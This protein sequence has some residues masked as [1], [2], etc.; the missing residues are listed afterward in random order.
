M[1]IKINNK[2]SLYFIEK[3]SYEIIQIQNIVLK[4]GSYW[5]I[6]PVICKLLNIQIYSENE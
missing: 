3:F 6:F 2:P 1:N 4:I 5:G